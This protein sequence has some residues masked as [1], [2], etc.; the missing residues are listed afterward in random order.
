MRMIL[1]I[2]EIKKKERLRDICQTFIYIY[3]SPFFF[4]HLRTSKTKPKYNLI[5]SMVQLLLFYF[6]SISG[7]ES[8]N[9]CGKKRS[10]VNDIA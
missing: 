2:R 6:L 1:A 4:G 10:M 9:Q 5:S 8:G 3:F 7:I